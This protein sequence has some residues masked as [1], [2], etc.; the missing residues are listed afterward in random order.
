MAPLGSSSC[1]RSAETFPCT[2][3]TLRAFSSSASVRSSRRRSATFST[4]NG[5]TGLRPR[6][7]SS[8]SKDPASRCLVPLTQNRR[9][10]P[11]TTQQRAHL[12]RPR[13]RIS[14][15]QNL[16]LILRGKPSPLRT[17]D[18]LPSQAAPPARHCRQPLRS[19]R[20][21]LAPLHDR[22]HAPAPTPTSCTPISPS[23]L[24]NSLTKTV[25]HDIGREEAAEGSGPVCARAAP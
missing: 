15:T 4:S 1:P 21:R 20:L 18:Q 7:R 6:S 5:S 16:Q 23:E 3:I 9:V 17:L 10:Q 24:S 19:A 12:A 8:T 25:S 2:S 13:T 22:R 11:L 14:L